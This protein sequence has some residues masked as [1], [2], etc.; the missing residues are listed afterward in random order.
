MTREIGVVMRK[1]LRGL[2][3]VR[4]RPECGAHPCSP[5][6]ERK[7]RV[8]Q[9]IQRRVG[10]GKRPHRHASRITPSTTVRHPCGSLGARSASNG[11]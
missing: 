6:A 1:E 3:N 9:Q 8:G 10:I 5:P 7:R 2:P 4:E 11:P